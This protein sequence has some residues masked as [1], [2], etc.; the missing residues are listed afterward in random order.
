MEL[1]NVILVVEDR[2]S[3]AVSTKIL[4]H[5]DIEI[6]QRV[7]YEGD[8]YLQ[9]KAQSYNHAAHQECGVFM[10]TDLDSPEICPPT[11]IRSWVKG[12][13]NRWFLLRVAVMEIESW[14]MADRQAVSEF[15]AI[16]TNRIPQ[17]T[18]EIP[19]PKEFLVSLAQRSK[20]T[21]LR[22]AL[23]PARSAKTAKT[24]NEYNPLLSQFVREHWNL[25]RAA[26][27]SP[28]LK[29]TLNRI[30]QGRNASTNQ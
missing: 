5:F 16:P 10:L 30:S 19:S 28:S 24:G 20:N 2:L 1:N 8:S 23:V 12:S 4:Q 11:L 18:D 22:K 9:R 26:S 25:E 29:R 15:L 13:L 17:N 7:I 21:R 3:D 14:I 6:V 27:V